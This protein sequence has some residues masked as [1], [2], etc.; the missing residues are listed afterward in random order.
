MVTNTIPTLEFSR[1]DEGIEF[2]T[3][4][5]G[6]MLVKTVNT[7]GDVFTIVLNPD[8]VKALRDLLILETA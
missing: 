1:N 5:S 8:E 7:D 6:F 4:D 3:S 2:H